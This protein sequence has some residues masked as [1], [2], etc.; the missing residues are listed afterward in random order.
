MKMF[1]YL[2]NLFSWGPTW[3]FKPK[4]DITVKE[5]ADIVSHATWFQN[6]GKHNM[7]PRGHGIRKKPWFKKHWQEDE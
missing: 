7:G 5:L 3:S 6:V 4:D 1:E 2:K